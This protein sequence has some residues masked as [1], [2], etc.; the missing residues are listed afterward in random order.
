MDTAGGGQGG[1][2]RGNSADTHAATHETASGE[3]LSHPRSS[4]QCSMTIKGS[5]GIGWEG[6]QV[7]RDTCFIYG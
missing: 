7:G 1:T 5:S 6:G 3:L 4:A 2:D